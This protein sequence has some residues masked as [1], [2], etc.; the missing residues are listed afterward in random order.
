MGQEA[1]LLFDHLH[2]TCVCPSIFGNLITYQ[3]LHL[4]LTHFVFS[5]SAELLFGS[6]LLYHYRLIER[7]W[8]SAKFASFIA[9]TAVFSSAIYA[10]VLL[11]LGKYVGVQRLASGPYAFVYACLFYSFQKIPVSQ[12]FNV[13]GVTFS[14]KS[15]I[16]I[17][18]LQVV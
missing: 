5:N 17:I 3:P 8:G 11:V 15:Y 9:F 7:Q 10:T 4:A 14:D 1:A 18:A 12:K 16:Y 13:F 6:V 2:L